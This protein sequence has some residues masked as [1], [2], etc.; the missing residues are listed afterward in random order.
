MTIKIS[1]KN[2][3]DKKIPTNYVIFV[4]ENFNISDLK[5]KY[6]RMNILLF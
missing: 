6:P 2:N 4:Q 5:K 1:Y 3:L